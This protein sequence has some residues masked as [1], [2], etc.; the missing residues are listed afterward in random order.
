MG[1]G[2]RRVVGANIPLPPL[3]PSLS[4]SVTLSSDVMLLC[5]LEAEGPP[6]GEEV[7]MG[8]GQLAR[9]GELGASS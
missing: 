4:F 8:P 1:W 5:N 9:S 3:S 7:L 2:V 6:A